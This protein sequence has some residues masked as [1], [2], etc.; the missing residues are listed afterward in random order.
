MENIGVLTWCLTISAI[1]FASVSL[2]P[3]CLMEAPTPVWLLTEQEWKT[4]ITTCRFMVGVKRVILRHLS[5]I[6]NH[7]K[8]MLNL[9][10][11]S[12]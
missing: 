1:L 9:E 7:L 2:A 6:F 3:R 4:G 8:I 12:C 10:K 5:I 11:K